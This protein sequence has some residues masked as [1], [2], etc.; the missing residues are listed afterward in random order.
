MKQ[1]V[2]IEPNVLGG[3]PCFAGTRVPI[4]SLFD[5]LKLGYSIEG[6][7]EQFPTVT[8]DQVDAL[9]EQSSQQV[10]DLKLRPGVNLDSNAALAEAMDEE[11]VNKMRAPFRH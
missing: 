11:L 2:Q 9:L 7:L 5:H 8:R 1:V 4:R 10:H 3:T 6:F